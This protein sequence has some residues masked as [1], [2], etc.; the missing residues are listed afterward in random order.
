MV[1]CICECGVKKRVRY[2]HL[3]S[4]KLFSCGCYRLERLR[5]VMVKHGKSN[6]N[7][8][9]IWEG[10]IQRC[11]NSKSANYNRY[12]GRGICVCDEWLDFSKFYKDM[13]D[14]PVGMSLDRIDNDKGYSKDNC[15]WA[16]PSVQSFNTNTPRNNTSGH[17]GVSWSESKGKWEAYITKDRRKINLGRFENIEDAISARKI[18]E[19]LYFPKD[20]PSVYKCEK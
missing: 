15:R 11:G 13:G 14:K 20:L 4:G 10:M 8:Y 9:Q 16:T 18:A 5:D 6:C 19:E 1:D 7:I 17:K 3:N 12:G 2:D